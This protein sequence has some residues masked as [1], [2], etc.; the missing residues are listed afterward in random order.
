MRLC[1]GAYVFLEYN[2]SMPDQPPAGS[3]AVENLIPISE[4][5]FRALFEAAGDAIFLMDNDT[6]LACNNRTLEMFG[7]TRERIIGNHPFILSPE[8]QPDGRPSKD[9]ALEKIS[10]AL[11]GVVQ[12]FPWRHVRC[13]GDAFDAEVTLT[14][15]QLDGKFYL[16]AI[17]RDKTEETTLQHQHDRLVSVVEN[18]PDFVGI[19]TPDGKVTYINDAF[20][21]IV[22]EQ[23]RTLINTPGTVPISAF[24]PP[25]AYTLLIETAIPY[26]ARH[27]IW[28]GENMLL[29]SLGHEFPTVQTI[30]A[31]TDANG[32]LDYFSTIVRD[33]SEFKERE[34]LLGDAE[35]V[36]RLGTYVTDTR[37]GQWSS[38]PILDEI[39]GI[40]K[41]YPRDVPGWAALIHPDEQKSMTEYYLN[42]VLGK[43]KR[44]DRVY[45]IIRHNDGVERWVQGLGGLTFDHA[46][47]PIR[48]TGTIQD[49]TDR[50][51]I[52]RAATAQK[53]FAQALID[54]SLDVIT[55][56]TADGTI[57]YES[58]AITTVFGYTLVELIGKNVFTYIH[59]DDLEAAKAAFAQALQIE[60]PVAPITLRF[61]H[62]NG[63]WIYTQVVGNNQLD[64]P[65]V[66]GV[67]LNSRDITDLMQMQNIKSHADEL[68]RLNKL[69]VDREVKMSELKEE[70]AALKER[71]RE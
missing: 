67:L 60:G 9:A 29:D 28:Q 24:H 30:I 45:R 1:T 15:I 23:Y 43:K 7:C 71:L 49:I 2:E 61:K 42:E 34:Q 70:L 62:K 33:I 35:R 17:V 47:N 46:G 58:K 19:A 54:N 25:A 55:I 20:R 48:M 36:A 4:E 6:F 64:N 56:I 18:T 32:E 26:A 22:P 3:S 14:R 50:I 57:K 41:S 44:F 21:R 52:E 68:E 11:G 8:K 5:F 51:M 63:S 38:S 27:G 13:N 31:H 12:R 10:A 40:D 37:T 39:F 65:K 16:Q 69:M 66:Q 53:E 59:P